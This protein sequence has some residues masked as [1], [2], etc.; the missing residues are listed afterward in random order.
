MRPLSLWADLSLSAR[1]HCTSDTG[2]R[3]EVVDTS[4]GSTQPR[5]NYNRAV[6]AKQTGLRGSN[7][8][9]QVQRK[10]FLHLGL[11]RTLVASRESVTCFWDRLPFQ[12]VDRTGGL[13]FPACFLCQS[14]KR[15]FCAVLL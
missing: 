2:Y 6:G 14:A 4:A 7:I 15:F 8:P 10:L 12:L 5:N 3:G 11:R 1:S 13:Y 9:L